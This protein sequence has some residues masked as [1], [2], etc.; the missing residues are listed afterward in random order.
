MEPIPRLLD[1]QS[2]LARKSCFLFGPR[3]TG[4]A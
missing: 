3:Q 2:V 1:I 4:K